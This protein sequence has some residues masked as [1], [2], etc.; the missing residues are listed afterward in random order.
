MTAPH[1]PLR[2]VTAR[3]TVADGVYRQLRDAL[4]VGRF[5]PGESLTIGAMAEAVQTSHMPVREA[6]RRL[7]A[8]GALEVGPGG[9]AR[10]PEV[11]Q[12]RLADI[13]RTRVALEGMAAELAAQR[14]TAADCDALE[15]LARA[16]AEA[17]QPGADFSAGLLTN[18][19][20]HFA[21]Y[22]LSGSE[23]MPPLIERLWLQ[24]GPFM[25]LLSARLAQQGIRRAQD[26]FKEGHAEIVEALRARDAAAV[27]AGIALDIGRTQNLLREALEGR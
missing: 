9:S 24:Y 17:A 2:P 5:A 8:E 27:R 7:T 4:I 11:T 21:L 23:V 26:P 18:R 13:G 6:L 16:H 3:Q 10:V 1:S 14:A 12:D 25:R 22:A 15:R 19:D 20:F